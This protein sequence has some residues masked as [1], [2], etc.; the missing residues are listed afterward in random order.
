SCTPSLPTKDS[1]RKRRVWSKAGQ[2]ELM[3]L[4][5]PRWTSQRRQ[6]WQELLG[7][8]NQRI[9]PLD[10]ALLE[11]AEQRPE[12]Q[13]LMTHPGVGPVTATAFVQ[14]VSK[15]GSASRKVLTAEASY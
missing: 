6:D 2:T 15:I 13:L 1:I 7:E 10:A 8:F 11:Q 3:A 14:R 5:L 9:R 4:A 12:I